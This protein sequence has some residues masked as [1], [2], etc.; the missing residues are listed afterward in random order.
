MGTDTVEQSVGSRKIPKLEGDGV[1]I[2][3][4]KPSISRAAELKN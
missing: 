3:S 4:C 1:A 2:R